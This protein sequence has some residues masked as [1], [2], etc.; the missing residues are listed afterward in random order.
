MS[1]SVELSAAPKSPTTLPIKACSLSGS[2]C[3]LSASLA[4]LILTRPPERYVYS[5][6]WKT[7]E[8]LLLG[9]EW[10]KLL[11][12]N[13]RPR[14]RR[15]SQ[16]ATRVCPARGLCE[17]IAAGSKSQALGGKRCLRQRQ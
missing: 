7:S 6:G 14:Q 13:A 10:R 8:G 15:G 11:H 3:L 1:T 17:S 4:E 9:A 5:R 2:I 16:K 12:P